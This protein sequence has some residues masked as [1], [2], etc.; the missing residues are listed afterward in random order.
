MGNR[1]KI[2]AGNWKMNKTFSEAI[3]L[4]SEILE[5]SK[6]TNCIKIIIPPFPFIYSIGEL[7]K[8]KPDFF[9]GAQNIHDQEQG[10]F[11]GE[12]AASA[13]T[14]VGARFVLIGHSERR[15]YFNE[16]APFLKNKMNTA[17]KNQL[18]PIYCFGE[19]LSERESNNH[20]QAIEKQLRDSCFHLKEH[21]I[22]NTVLAY[23]PVWAIGTGKT[24]SPEQ[25]QEIH[26]FVR[27][28]IKTQYSAEV[29]E[30]V[31]ILYGGSCNAQ[32]ASALFSMPD[33]DGGL[34]GGASL[35][36]NDFIA[37]TASFL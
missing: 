17:L 23:E 25:A 32:N 7:I 11:T 24:A 10:A 36:A 2:V 33:I 19:S 31:S 18:T 8:T 34:I 27:S 14:S 37:I 20:K 16:E 3:T 35:K 5:L 22:K 6:D 29:A 9:V 26:H 1:K 30:M 12:V 21:E 28:L 4:T 15:A 13:L